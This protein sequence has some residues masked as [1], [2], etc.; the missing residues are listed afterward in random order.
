V[1]HR[2]LLVDSQREMLRSLRAWLEGAFGN[3]VQIEEAASGEEALLLPAKA[4]VDLVVSGFRLPGLGGLELLHRLRARAPHVAAIITYSA[5]DRGAR[6][7]MLNAGAAAIFEKP[8]PAKAF[9]EAVDACLAPAQLRSEPQ[10]DL[11]PDQARHPRLADALANF[12]QDHAAF[13]VLLLDQEGRVLAR[14]GDLP[15][16]EVEAAVRSVLGQVHT[17]SLGLPMFAGQT[18]PEALT[19]YRSRDVD[20]IFIVISSLH[21]LLVAGPDFGGADRVA[22]SLQSASDLARE[23]D[24]ILESI[25][26][27]VA[28]D[29]AGEP[30]EVISSAD[31]PALD[32]RIEALLDR[33]AK[34]DDSELDVYWEQAAAA[35]K[36]SNSEVAGLSFD[37]A[38]RLGLAGDQLDE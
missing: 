38:K 25:G 13:A 20:L 33:G 6:D 29:A 37:E 14:A 30:P 27:E 9:R 26:A 16:D 10:R 5:A 1:S 15:G 19:I 21:S 8:V 32:S 7:Q 28:A 23:L 22:E 31:Q 3:A 18:H 36:E 34:V 35:R 24:G 11:E 2:I 17:A 4:A 12:R